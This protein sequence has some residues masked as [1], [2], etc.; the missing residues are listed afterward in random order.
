[1]K[2]L[3]IFIFILFCL[4]VYSSVD[5]DELGSN[6]NFLQNQLPFSS[7]SLKIVQK[8]WLPKRFLSELSLSISPVLNGLNYV[9]SYSLSGNYRLFVTDYLSFHLKYSWYFNSITEEGRKE[10]E[11]RSRIPFELKYSETQSYLA[12]VDWYPFY[13]KAVLYNHLIY[14]NLYASLM[15]GIVKLMNQ[16]KSAPMGSL[17]LGMVCWWNKRFNTRL[18]VQGIYYQYNMS[19]SKSIQEYLSKLH[20][21]IGVL[22]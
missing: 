22:F 10:V 17:G 5:F 20:V 13:G 12:G 4:P 18:E 16:D 14:F 7:S 11:K 9:N 2:K 15:G 6:K 21:S 3:W 1:M 19:I 8:Q